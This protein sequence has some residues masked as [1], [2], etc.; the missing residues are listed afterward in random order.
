MGDGKVGKERPYHRMPEIS[1]P[2]IGPSK[3]KLPPQ[4]TNRGNGIEHADEIDIN[5]GA[6]IIFELSALKENKGKDPPHARATSK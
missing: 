2:K 3:R 4:E 1:D 6:E 5:V